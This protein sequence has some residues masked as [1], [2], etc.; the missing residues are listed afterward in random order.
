MHVSAVVVG[1]KFFLLKAYNS[2]HVDDELYARTESTEVFCLGISRR[3]SCI[4][5]RYC[6]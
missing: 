6:F 1:E 5:C 2:A 4:G 3:V